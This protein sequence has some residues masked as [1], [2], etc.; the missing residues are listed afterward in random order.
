MIEREKEDMRFYYEKFNITVQ[1]ISTKNTYEKV[2]KFTIPSFL[3]V[4]DEND[5]R[6]MINLLFLHCLLP[7]MTVGET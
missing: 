1:V 3:A 4:K 2:N 7:R 5:L 6:D